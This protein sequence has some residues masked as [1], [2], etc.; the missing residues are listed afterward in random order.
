M[1]DVVN[2]RRFRK[3]QLRVVKAVAADSNRA[4]FGRSKTERLVGETER[5]RNDARLDGHR[6]DL[7]AD[8][9][10]EPGG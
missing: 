3:S 5:S 2:L 1:A 4:L 6:R 8:R 7:V 9:G 10:E